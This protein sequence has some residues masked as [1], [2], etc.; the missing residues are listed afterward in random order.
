MAEKPLDYVRPLQSIALNFV[1]H[2]NGNR[3]GERGQQVSHFWE[4]PFALDTRG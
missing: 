3:F 2:Q 4:K 1:P